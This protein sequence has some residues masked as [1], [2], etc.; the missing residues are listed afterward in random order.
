MDPEPF[1]PTLLQIPRQ[2]SDL[3]NDYIYIY[4]HKLIMINYRQKRF[5][6]QTNSG[7]EGGGGGTNIFF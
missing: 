4:V 7:A 6:L 5:L 2:P 3:N 1:S